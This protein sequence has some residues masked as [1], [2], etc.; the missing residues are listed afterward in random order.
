M[1]LPCYRHTNTGNETGRGIDQSV[2]RGRGPQY[3]I[4]PTLR[5][6]ADTGLG[7]DEDA[8]AIFERLGVVRLPAVPL[9]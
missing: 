5:A 9:P 7:L 2:A 6:R 1:L 8:Q 3:E 4:A